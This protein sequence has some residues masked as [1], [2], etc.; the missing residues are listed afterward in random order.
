MLQMAAAGFGLAVLFAQSAQFLNVV[1]WTGVIYLVFM[2]V[3][4]FL[5]MPAKGPQLD[6][7]AATTRQL[8]LQ[9]FLTSAANPKAVLFFAALF[10][11][12][13]N[14]SDPIWPQLSI[15]GV[16]YLL[17]DGCL[18]FAYGTVAN[19][20]LGR[21]KNNTLLLDRLSGVLMIGAALLLATKSLEVR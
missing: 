16:T 20:L 9:G 11:K 14:A 10:P 12:F 4:V 15:L 3:R 17:I 7:D 6:I 5:A 19:S 21:L 8:Y 18:L 13:I 1:K 2:G